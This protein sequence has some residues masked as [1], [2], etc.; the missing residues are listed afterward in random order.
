LEA[1]RLAERRHEDRQPEKRA[2]DGEEGDRPAH[3]RW[4]LVAMRP[5]LA[6]EGALEEAG[7]VQ[8]GDRDARQRGQPHQPPDPLRGGTVGVLG[9]VDDAFL[10]PEA[11]E[12]RE[13]GERAQPDRERPERHRHVPPKPAHP[14]H[15]VAA[16]RVDHAAGGEEEQRLERG[17][18]Q[19][20]EEG[21]GGG[22]DRE[23]TGHVAD[24]GDGGPGEHALDVV[25]RG[26]DERAEQQ[27]DGRHDAQDRQDGAGEQRVEAR[28]HVDAGRHHRRGVDER[29]DRRGAGHR[30]GQ[31]RVQRELR[32][33]ARHTG[34][35]QQPGDGE[36]GGAVVVGEHVG[37]AERARADAEHRDTEEETD[38]AHAGDD[39]RLHRGGGRLGEAAVVA[40]EQVRA[41]AHHLPPHQQHDQ[42]TGDD[43]QQHGGGEEADLS[44]VRRVALV[45]GQV[46]D[47][48]D[49]YRQRDHADRDGDERGR[50]IDPHAEGDAEVAD[51]DPFA[52][53]LGLVDEYRDDQRPGGSR[54]T[55]CRRGR[56]GL[57]RQE[58]ADE[59]GGEG[60]GREE[61]PRDHAS[62]LSSGTS[63]TATLARRR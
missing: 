46:G 61:H 45:V 30:V 34:E 40:D 43:D 7:G 33:L 48:V 24:L 62:I 42:V 4:G 26:R 3:E 10:A 15:Q 29:G 20:V 5:G 39:E 36:G 50:L 52:A 35:Q 11:G 14:R 17:V 56:T 41:D 58:E 54:D 12:R 53:V 57:Q 25:L 22:A 44:G 60:Y 59:R 38:I 27:R 9:G 23:R 31:P 21:G 6:E 1:Q 37:D 16:D 32:T 18:R 13:A 28:D 63:S 47:R 49:L 8:G 55:Q 19:Q 2:G 51:P